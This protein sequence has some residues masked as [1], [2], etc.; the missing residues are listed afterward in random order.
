MIKEYFTPDEVAEIFGVSANQIRKLCKQGK[1]NHS[2]IGS[3]YRI[4]GDA[5]ESLRIPVQSPR[6]LDDSNPKLPGMEQ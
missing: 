2:K 4:H 1:L 3:L 5:V 6:F